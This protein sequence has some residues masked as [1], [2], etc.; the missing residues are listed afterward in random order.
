MNN[1]YNIRR[2]VP[3]LEL[4]IAAISLSYAACIVLFLII[5]MLAGVI[6]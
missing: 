3:K 4:I 6:K 2:H 1:K 5:I